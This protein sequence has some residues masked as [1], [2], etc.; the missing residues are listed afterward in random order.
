MYISSHIQIYILYAHTIY[1]HTYVQY[2]RT[3]Y[4][5][6]YTLRN[7][8]NTARGVSLLTYR[9][10]DLTVSN[11]NAGEVWSSTLN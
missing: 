11:L 3:Q 4:I 1:I 5:Q 2:I 10:F 8:R 6:T 7:K 9:V